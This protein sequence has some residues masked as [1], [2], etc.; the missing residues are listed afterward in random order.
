MTP[1]TRSA[2]VTPD[3]Q[4]L[5]AYPCDLTPRARSSLM[6]VLHE[7]LARAR[8]ASV[9]SDAYAHERARRLLVLR[10]AQR[11]YEQAGRRARLASA[12]VR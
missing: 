6:Y 2:A 8:V 1:P 9:R 7:E 5:S 11:R 10:R 3:F 4:A 12:A